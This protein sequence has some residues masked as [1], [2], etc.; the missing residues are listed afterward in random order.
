MLDPT[1]SY[2]LNRFIER[3]LIAGLIVG[4]VVVICIVRWLV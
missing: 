3:V 1:D 2:H 4:A